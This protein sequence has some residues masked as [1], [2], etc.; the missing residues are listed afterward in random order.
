M[1]PPTMMHMSVKM[2]ASSKALCMKSK[3]VMYVRLSLA[4]YST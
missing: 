3:T 1:P 2:G 4:Y